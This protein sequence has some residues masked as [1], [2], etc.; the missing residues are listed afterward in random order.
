MRVIDSTVVALYLLA[1][2]TLGFWFARRKQDSER[3][4]AA[5][6]SLP[7]WAV[8]LSIFGTY[9]SSIS[10]LANPGKSYRENW[11]GFVFSLSLPL[12]AWVAA[13]FFVPFYRRDGEV[14]AY[15]HLERRFGAWARTYA[16]VC[17]L[18]TQLVRSGAIMCLLAL[19]LTQLTGWS[20]ATIIVLTGI[21]MTLFP[22]VGGTEAVIWTGVVQSVVLAVGA[23]TCMVLLI[24]GM[25]EGPGQLLNVAAAHDKFSLGS[26]DFGL[27]APTFWVVLV[28]GVAINLQNFGIDQSYVQRYITARSDEAGKRSVWFGAAMYIPL[29]AVFF[30]I[31]TALFAFYAARPELLAEGTT[32]DKVFPYFIR[33][34]LPIG[35]AGLVI[36]AICAAG[37]D[38]TFNSTSTLILR[39]IYLRYLRPNASESESMT[40]LRTS[41]VLFGVL[42]IVIAFAFERATNASAALDVWWRWSGILG[43]GTL[44]LFLLGRMSKRA[45]GV[46]G[47]AGVVAATLLSLWMTFSKDWTR[48][49]GPMRSPFHPFLVIVF[50]TIVVLGV[51]LLVALVRKP[52]TRERREILV[53]TSASVS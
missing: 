52:R 53:D 43:G 50:C 13:K 15:H 16:V 40:V 44:G 12:A 20:A 17:Y 31:G 24:V 41:T 22:L 51:G 11:N 33:N 34:Q 47:A 19:A 8:G 42:A 29:S 30:F 25:P 27:G 9:V 38:S 18:L 3:F 26:F 35:M 14:S 21:L 1:T 39:D 32:G 10:F 4:M 45:D 49:P 5:G 2:L 23:V 37:T 7:G 46:G 48:L 6:R 28:Y 36:A